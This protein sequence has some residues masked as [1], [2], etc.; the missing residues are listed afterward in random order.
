M[1]RKK[2]LASKQKL[3]QK[4]WYSS[5]SFPRGK[6]RVVRFESSRPKIAQ[7][8]FVAVIILAF[9]RSEW[10]LFVVSENWRSSTRFRILWLKSIVSSLRFKKKKY[11]RKNMGGYSAGINTQINIIDSA[12][13]NKY[14]QWLL[15]KNSEDYIRNFLSKTQLPELQSAL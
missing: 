12:T 7:V 9:S 14:F 3:P 8:R 10:S 11:R 13:E 15:S 1:I 5:L 4:R 6:M 2:S